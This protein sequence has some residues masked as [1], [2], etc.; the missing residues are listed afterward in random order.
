MTTTMETDPAHDPSPQLLTPQLLTAPLLDTAPDTDADSV[1]TPVIGTKVLTNPDVSTEYVVKFLF[2]PNKDNAGSEVARMHFALLESIHKIYSDSLTIYDNY[3]RKLKDFAPPRSYDGYLR[4]FKVHYSKPNLNKNRKG[5]YTCFHRV[6]S[7][8]PIGEIRKHATISALLQKLNTRMSLHLWHEDDTQIT[9]LGFFVGIDP[10]NFLSDTTAERIR[11]FIAMDTKKNIKNIPQFKLV[12]S[13]PFIILDSGHRISTKSYDLQVRKQDAKLMIDYLRKAYVSSPTFIFHRIRHSNLDTYTN[14]I[15]RQNAF[16]STSR[17]VPLAGI[18]TD[19]MFSLELEIKQIPGVVDVLNHK[20]TNKIGRWNVL[21]T[22][23]AF[24]SVTDRL[25]QLIP[26]WFSQLSETYDTPPDFPQPGLAF[27][28]QQ[29]ESDSDMS[30]ESYVSACS[31]IYQGIDSVNTYDDPPAATLPPAQAWGNVAV[32]KFLTTYQAT[33]IS[34]V[35]SEEVDTLRRENEL[36]RK[37]LQEIKTLLQQQSAAQISAV[38]LQQV[39][40]AATHAVL[41][42]LRQLYPPPDPGPTVDFSSA[43]ST[44]VHP[45][46]RTDTKAT[47]DYMSHSDR[48]ITHDQLPRQDNNMILTHDDASHDVPM[49]PSNHD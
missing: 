21:T 28:T 6:Y 8:I 11:K 19:M 16:L 35:S 2:R 38:N 22:D 45:K 31:S 20:Q 33:M 37:E 29:Y 40:D 48:A 9:S 23:A 43:P 30:F 39:T 41:A 7:T 24:R 14:A 4:H 26:D 5:T 34:E 32:P 17:V 15:K 27:R 10:A 3:N 47:P 49:P 36:L 18:S 13:S 12:Y 46:K 42:A 44:P 25:T 1:A